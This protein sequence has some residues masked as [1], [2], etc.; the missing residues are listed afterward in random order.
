MFLRLAE[1]GNGTATAGESHEEPMESESALP[2]KD[3]DAENADNLDSSK[4]LVIVDEPA[5]AAAAPAGD[6]EMLED[7]LIDVPTENS[8]PPAA[9]PAVTVTASSAVKTPIQ[10]PVNDDKEKDIASRSIWV[11][12]LTSATK[13]ADLKVRI[14]GMFMRFTL[15]K[16]QWSVSVTH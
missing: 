9:K 10:A 16:C 5:A 8:A 15:R 12:G 4:E 7:P 13:A 1:N 3:G 2:A 6:E 14:I 11:R